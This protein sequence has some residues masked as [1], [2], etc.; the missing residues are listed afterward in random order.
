M[1]GGAAAAPSAELSGSGQEVGLERQGRNGWATGDAC[2]SR[3]SDPLAAVHG[4]AG[5]N[6]TEGFFLKTALKAFRIPWLGGRIAYLPEREDARI[7][8]REVFATR[9][10]ARHVDPHGHLINDKIAEF[11]RVLGYDLGSGLV[12]N[13]GVTAMANDPQWSAQLNLSTLGTQNFHATGT[14]TTAAAA[15]D[16]ALQTLASPT[17][18][19]A[20]TGAQTLVSAA[21]LQKFQNVAT[22][23][24]TSSLAITEWG[25]HSLATL[26]STTGSPF[27]AATATTWTDTGSA[28]TASSATVRGLQQT[29]VVPGTT[30]VY[31]LNLSNTTHVGTIPAWYKVADGTAGSTPGNTETFAIKPVLWDHKVFSAINVINGDSIQFTYQLTVNSGG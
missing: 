6:S 5:S 7:T 26:S 4:L 20:V 12:T 18:T 16:I 3:A 10:F 27:T 28:Q 24:Y 31:G 8:A 15:T 14:G 1:R 11:D 23:N 21:N 9:L 25:L 17:T 30:T 19:T 22:V 2:D 13:V 29:I